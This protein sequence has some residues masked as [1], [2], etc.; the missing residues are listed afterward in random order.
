MDSTATI[1]LERALKEI[2]RAD[3]DSGPTVAAPDAANT[4]VSYDEESSGDASSLRD[5]GLPLVYNRDAIQQYWKGR[6]GELDSRWRQFLTIVL[7]L[8]AKTLRSLLF[9]GLDALKKVE[10][11]L[12]QESRVAAEKLG[13]TYVKGGQM[14]SVRPDV[15]SPVVMTELAKLQVCQQNRK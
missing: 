13:P 9:G 2:E 6:P 11:E 1:I 4:F 3:N 7:P 12:A 5:D 15:L 10:G 14:M 8:F